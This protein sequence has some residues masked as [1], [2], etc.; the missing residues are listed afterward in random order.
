[1]SKL[2]FLFLLSCICHFHVHAQSDVLDSLPSV[3]EPN[4]VDELTLHTRNDPKSQASRN[5]DFPVANL[6]D[7]T[8][9]NNT[10]LPSSNIT[11]L[12]ASSNLTGTTLTLNVTSPHSPAVVKIKL[13]PLILPPEASVL[14]KNNESKIL[15]PSLENNN[16]RHPVNATKPWDTTKPPVGARVVRQDPR[17]GEFGTI[18]AALSF[19]KNLTAQAQNVTQT[20]FIY[21]GTYN[22]KLIVDYKGPLKMV[23][24]TVDRHNF[25]QNLVNINGSMGAQKAGSNELS[26]TVRIIKDDFSMYNINVYNSYGHQGHLSQAIALS[27]T[28]SRQA[29]YACSFF[30]Y[31]DTLLTLN[32]YHYYSEC[33][34]Q[35]AVDFIFTQKAV[36]WFEKA[37]IGSVAPGVISANGRNDAIN[38][39]RYVF[40]RA[41]VISKGAAIGSVYLARPWG[42]YSRTTF[43]FSYLSEVV[44]PLAWRVWQDGDTRT[45]HA[46]YTEYRNHGPGSVLFPPNWNYTL[47]HSQEPIDVGKPV[48]GSKVPVVTPPI[49][50]NATSL[51]VPPGSRAVWGKERARPCKI[52]QVLGKDYAIWIDPDFG[53]DPF[54][55]GNTENLAG[56]PSSNGTTINL[57][58]KETSNVT[59]S[60]VTGKDP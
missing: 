54:S 57:G 3:Q 56:K 50:E 41:K 40:N 9:S 14:P 30:G 19:L 21:P 26:A 60:T 7:W 24:Y 20:I 13:R 1:M 58:G 51:G 47:T 4:L 42:N 2:S 53:V 43:Q 28:G 31:Q 33:Y 25:S 22:E 8:L 49:V 6:S 52:T 16:L 59:A 36:V 5:P 34:I 44:N 37:T 48:N 39:S 15:K 32:G 10:E 35:G 17:A 46:S 29:Y 12:Q 27:G 45:N 11:E 23:G 38:P 18:Q 55:S